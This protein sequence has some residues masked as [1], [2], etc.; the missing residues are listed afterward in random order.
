MNSRPCLQE[1]I[2]EQAGR[3][4]HNMSAPPRSTVS[5]RPYGLAQS[6]ASAPAPSG[7]TCGLQW[8]LRADPDALLKAALPDIAQRMQDLRQEALS[9][10]RGKDKQAASKNIAKLRSLRLAGLVSLAADLAGVESGPGGTASDRQPLETLQD[11]LTDLAS[12]LPDPPAWLPALAIAES[13][14]G[15]GA[16]S[17][18]GSTDTLAVLWA[19]TRINGRTFDREGIPHLPADLAEGGAYDLYVPCWKEQP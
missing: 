11:S 1:H 18:A 3:L 15:G 7:Q 12:R 5:F 9:Q 14:A 6:T 17:D 10:A 4:A 16:R 13:L 19:L 8:L 2:E